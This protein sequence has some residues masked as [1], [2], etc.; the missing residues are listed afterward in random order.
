MLIKKISIIILF[1]IAIFVGFSI[2]ESVKVN[3]E[4]HEKI[5]YEIESTIGAKTEYPECT[6]E[7]SFPK[8]IEE[9]YLFEHDKWE[10]TIQNTK[11]MIVGE[12][13]NYINN[14]NDFLSD[15]EKDELKAIECAAIDLDSAKSAID[16]KKRYS[17]IISKAEKK[18]NAWEEEQ[19]RKEEF[20]K[21]QQASISG[22][23]FKRDGIWRDSQFEYSWYSSNVLRHYRTNEWTPDSN[24]IYRDC[25]GYVCAASDDYSLGTVLDTEKFGKVII[26]DTGVGT[27]G[28]LDIYTNF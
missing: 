5:E 19:R 28:R 13:D 16:Y 18:K 21:E 11:K 10:A 22:S 6:I 24:G 23:Q 4:Y 27:S 17:K 8:Y 2:F 26:T 12:T 1:I 3:N 14:L 15:K 9:G 7:Y 20:K 25:N